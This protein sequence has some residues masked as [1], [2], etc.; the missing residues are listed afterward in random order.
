MIMTF[1]SC[2]VNGYKFR[3][4]DK[5]GVLVKGT[6]HVNALENY[7]GQL[8]EIIRL[9]YRG[10]NHVYL[11]KCCW[12][13]SAGSGVRVD[14]NRIVSIDIKSRLRSNEVFVLASQATQVYYAPSVLNPRSNFYTVISIKNSPL[15]ESTTPSTE[16]PYQEN[17]SNASTSIFSL[18]VDFAQYEPIPR[19]RFEDHDNDEVDDD[20]EDENNEEFDEED[21]ENEEEIGGG[22]EE[23]E[24]EEGYEDID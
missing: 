18:F 16:N 5:S 19:I 22:E 10:G 23:E 7:Y 11:F 9:V 17:I 13:D 4:K 12:F 15:D 21:Q 24:E 20:D 1:Q 8:E 6:S 14:K 3:C 2:K